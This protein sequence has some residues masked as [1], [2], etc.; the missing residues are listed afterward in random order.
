KM[1]LSESPGSIFLFGE[2]AVVYS[3]P[4]I[5]ASVNLRTRCQ[6][7]K[8]V[9]RYI[10]IFSRELGK[11]VLKEKKEGVKDLFVLL[12]LAKHLLNKYKIKNGLEIRIES[13]IPLE[14]GLSSSTAVLCS[15]LCS[16]SKLFDINIPKN[17]YY[18]H[19]IEFQKEIHGGKASGSEIISSSVGGFNYISFVKGDVRVK[20]LHKLPLGVVI[21][22]TTIRIKTSK[23]VKG[24]IPDLM[25]KKPDLVRKSFDKIELICKE[26]L[27]AIENKDIIRIG[28][29][30]N[31]NQQVL[32][33]LGLS[34]PKIDLAV[35]KALEAGAYGAKLSGK[36]QGGIM[37]AITNDENKHN[38]ADAIKSAGLKIIQ[39]EI[40]I[41]GV[42]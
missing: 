6:I 21:G 36:G 15:L 18:N 42:K 28:K 38:V 17:T 30:V 11:A 41:G 16:F 27:L 31:E 22:D 25:E 23:T 2:H 14:S 8:T 19:L 20:E 10:Y 3:K 7:D 34:H 37:F 32:S 1:T 40:G 9:D 12:D 13:D 29:L 39:T 35:K 5:V 26:G 33:S 4:A 24:Y